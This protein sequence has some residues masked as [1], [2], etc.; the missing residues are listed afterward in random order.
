MSS[1]RPRLATR[2]LMGMVRGYQLLFSAWLRADCRYSP[3]CSN[4]AMQ[5]LRQ[6]GAAAG[7]YLAAA[8]ILRCNP[9][10]LGGHDPVPD[11]PPRLFTR[12]TGCRPGRA[13]STAKSK[14]S[15]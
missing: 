7:T 10:C 6:H 8:R 14:A 3:S 1:D 13:T 4:Y 9:F 15:P 12:L 2:L 5:A 11:N